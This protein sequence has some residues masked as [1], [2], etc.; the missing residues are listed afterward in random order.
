MAI[1]RVNELLGGPNWPVPFPACSIPFSRSK[2]LTA[3][4]KGAILEK[5]V[6]YIEALKAANNSLGKQVN[7]TQQL[8]SDNEILRRQIDA[9]KAENNIMREQLERNGI[10]AADSKFNW[11]DW[12]MLYDVYR[13]LHFRRWYVGFSSLRLPTKRLKP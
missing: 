3:T 12:W 8:K 6:A 13:F 4:S 10:R 11:F 5:A 1:C 2:A 9:L 7:E